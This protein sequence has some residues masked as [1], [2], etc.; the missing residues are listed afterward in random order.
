MVNKPGKQ[1]ISVR[2]ETGGRVWKKKK[3]KGGKKPW[4]EKR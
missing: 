2:L 1:W 4:G 3:K